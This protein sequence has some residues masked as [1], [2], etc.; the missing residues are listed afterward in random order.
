MIYNKADAFE[1]SS[2]LSEMGLLRRPQQVQFLPLGGGE[3]IRGVSSVKYKYDSGKGKQQM[4][5]SK[6]IANNFLMI[7]TSSNFRTRN[8]STPSNLGTMAS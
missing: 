4:K 8:L 3:M 7:I 1:L 5:R 6:G 2:R